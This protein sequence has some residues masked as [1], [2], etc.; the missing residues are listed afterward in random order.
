MRNGSQAAIWDCCCLNPY[1]TGSTLWEA[2]I[3]HKYR[4]LILV[5]IL[6]ILE[7]LYERLDDC[8][9]LDLCVLIL[10]ILEVLYEV[11]VFHT[12]IQTGAVL[13][14]IILEV[15]YEKKGG[16]AGHTSTMCLNP[17]YTGSTLWGQVLL[18]MW[19][20]CRVLI[21]IILEVLYEAYVPSYLFC[22][23]QS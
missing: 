16:H 15:L 19:T 8:L 5:L 18:C 6:I 11:F 12:C 13:I 3:H 20:N 21:L 14:L 22:S 7:V 2:S 4:S 9:S 10:I 23:S 1:Y 17:Y